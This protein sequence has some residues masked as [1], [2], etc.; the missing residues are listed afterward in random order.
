M[1]S[2]TGAPE[3]LQVGGDEM[4]LR[5]TSDAERR[6]EAIAF[7]V[8]MPAGG[9]PPM[10]HRH[11]SL[12]IYRVEE[13]E[14]ASTSATPRALLE[15][16]WSAAGRR[17]SSPAARSTRSATSPA[18]RARLRRS[19][20]RR[21]AGGLREGGGSSGEAVEPSEVLRSPGLPRDRDHPPAG[22]RPTRLAPRVRLH[23]APA[24]LPGGLQPGP[25]KRIPSLSRKR[26]ARLRSCH[27]ATY[28]W[29]AALDRAEGADVL[30]QPVADALALAARR[31]RTS[32]PR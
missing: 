13:G 16:S 5:L 12:E 7:E 30:R 11:R 32:G 14:L 27:I 9:G 25:W 8:E 15:G 24:P 17:R 1:P 18:S 2:G 31:C 22:R 26:G 19:R 29:K 10:L 21:R 3:R 20:A 4:R 6:G 23:L 28:S